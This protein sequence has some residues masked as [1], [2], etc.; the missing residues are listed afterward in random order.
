MNQIGSALG[1]ALPKHFSMAQGAPS[2]VPRAVRALLVFGSLV[3]VGMAVQG[4]ILA[5]LV[6]LH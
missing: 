1:E 3:G 5:L 4:I 6:L 2:V